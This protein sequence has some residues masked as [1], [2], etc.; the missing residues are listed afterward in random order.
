VLGR[1]KYDMYD[2]GAQTLQR[3]YVFIYLGRVPP[4]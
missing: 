2:V 4:K 3:G 1:V